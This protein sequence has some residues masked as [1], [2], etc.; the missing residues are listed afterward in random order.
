MPP[1]TIPGATLLRDTSQ[2]S[3]FAGNATDSDSSELGKEAGTEDVAT[4]SQP[5]RTQRHR[6]KTRKASDL[7]VCDL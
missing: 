2:G 1:P 4:S 5:R 3:N 6:K 7:N